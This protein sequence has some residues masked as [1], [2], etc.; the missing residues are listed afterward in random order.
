MAEHIVDDCNAKLILPVCIELFQQFIIGTAPGKF[1]QLAMF[2]RRQKYRML[3]QYQLGKFG[4]FLIPVSFIERIGGLQKIFAALAQQ[5]VQAPLAFARAQV[6][7]KPVHVIFNKCDESFHVAR[8]PKQ[9]GLH[10]Q[11]D[12][13]A[14]GYKSLVNI[15]IRL[16]DL[17][18]QQCL[19][20]SF[21]P[22]GGFVTL[23][24]PVHL[25]LHCL[26]G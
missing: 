5:R 10:Q 7:L 26:I 21:P 15:Y 13:S 19:F 9:I 20:C 2:F 24:I 16:V 18:P 25:C 3:C 11:I 22:G 17:P 12:C 8:R 4:A 14:A 23:I 6:C 1:K